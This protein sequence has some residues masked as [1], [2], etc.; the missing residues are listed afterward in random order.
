[1]N[2]LII[3]YGD[4]YI[5]YYEDKKDDFIRKLDYKNSNFKELSNKTEVELILTTKLNENNKNLTDDL[6]VKYYNFENNLENLIDNVKNK[7]NKYKYIII[8][9][10]NYKINYDS[11]LKLLIKSNSIYFDNGLFFC[12][13][14]NFNLIEVTENIISLKES[15]LIIKNK[16]KFFEEIIDNNILIENLYAVLLL[17][18]NPTIFNLSKIK[19]TPHYLYLNNNTDPYEKYLNIENKNN[20]SLEIYNHLINNFDF[21]RNIIIQ[22]KIKMNRLII[23]DGLHRSSI[24]LNNNYKTVKIFK[25]KKFPLIDKP[26]YYKLNKIIH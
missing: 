20:H 12:R 19:K 1:M 15:N 2:V 8:S 24:L 5:K 10:F 21:K 3:L 7:I 22:A 18:R 14:E 23:Y 13:N 25:V 16:N 26:K 9:K 4:S 6:K 17:N 11:I